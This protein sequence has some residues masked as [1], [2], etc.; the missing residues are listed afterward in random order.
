MTGAL[1]GDPHPPGPGEPDRL[2]HVGGRLRHYDE[3][4]PLVGGQVPRLPR[5][6]IA[7]L[8]QGEDVAGN[9]GPQRFQIAAGHAV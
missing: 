3:S 6:V 7:G 5:L 1:R 2:H 8:A 9:R 4:R